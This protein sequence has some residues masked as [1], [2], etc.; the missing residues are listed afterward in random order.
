[1]SEHT[2]GPWHAASYSS[3]VGSPVVSASGRPIAQIVY[4]QLGEGFENHDRES[5]ANGA[6]I[7][8]APDLLEALKA[9]RKQLHAMGVGVDVRHAITDMADMAI[10][11]AEGRS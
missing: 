2:K 3:K 9:T 11:K 8:A 1:M 5:A 7:A 4:F 6:L 10:A